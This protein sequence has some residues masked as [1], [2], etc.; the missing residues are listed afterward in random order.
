M[1]IPAIAD[2]LERTPRQA[3]EMDQPKGVRYAVFS[4]AALAAMARD[5]RLASA[6]RAAAETFERRER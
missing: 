4:D 6:D 1:S 5:L 3:A 2:A